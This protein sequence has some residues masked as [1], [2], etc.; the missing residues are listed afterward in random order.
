ML[1]TTI[2]VAIAFKQRNFDG[3]LIFRKI[4]KSTLGL[5]FKDVLFSKKDDINIIGFPAPCFRC[6]CTTFKETHPTLKRFSVML[7]AFDLIKMIPTGLKCLQEDIYSKQRSPLKGQKQYGSMP[8]YMRPKQIESACID[9]QRFVLF[10]R[11][12]QSTPLKAIPFIT[13]T[14]HDIALIRISFSSPAPNQFS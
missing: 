1:K 10:Q 7:I 13:R 14:A 5:N 11:N 3:G 2:E 6:L 4:P 9:L 12:E 8:D